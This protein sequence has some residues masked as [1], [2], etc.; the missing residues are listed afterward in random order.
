[1][2]MMGKRLEKVQKLIRTALLALCLLLA[3]GVSAL[4]WFALNERLTRTDNLEI[5]MPP[6]IYIKDDNLQEMTSFQLDGLEA[7]VEYNAVFCVSPALNSV[8]KFFLGV[9]YTENMG[10][11][12]N[13]YPV[14]G[15]TDTAPAEGVF[16]PREITLGGNPQTCY[17]RYDN[18]IEADKTTYGDWKTE[19]KPEGSNL[20]TGIFKAYDG[21]K[22]EANNKEYESKVLKELNDTSRHLFFVLHIEWTENVVA[23][24]ETDIVYIVSKGSRGGGTQ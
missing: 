7:G 10:M 2:N 14:T 23:D 17:F 21:W 4:A 22:F 6:I 9:I 13:L 20:N 19:T 5:N 11:E 8:D 15:V 24:K 3:F 12:I 16:E 18:K 1:M